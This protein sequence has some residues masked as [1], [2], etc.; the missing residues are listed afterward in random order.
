MDVAIVTDSTCELAPGAE[1]RYAIDIVPL[2]VFFGEE[3]FRDGVDM[4]NEE[5]YSRLAKTKALPTTSQP[6]PA[7]F[8]E[9]FRRRLDE[10]KAVVGVF[11]SALL[12]GTFQ[13][14]MTA[15]SM[16]SAEEQE[17]IHLID[18]KHA[19]GNLALIVLE[20]CRMRDLGVDATGIARYLDEII[21]R[22]RLYAMLDTLHYL[23]M[24]G[25]LS[26]TAAAAGSVL[27]IAPILT[28]QDGAVTPCAKIH[29]NHNVFRKW[30]REKL[31]GAPPDPQCPV[32]FLHSNNPALAASLRD[33][34]GSLLPTDNACDLCLGATVGVHVGPN[35]YGLSYI[36]RE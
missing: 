6:S 5:F 29:K 26:A 9:F 28:M 31:L 33:D 12:S 20:A 19:T 36:S 30:L 15:R 13:S 3:V 32:A 7:V 22:V 10:G 23:K 21:P 35:A 16:F 8:Q 17:R 24:G 2:L 34:I 14:A 1:A 27:N 11:I 18:S 4:P 25:R